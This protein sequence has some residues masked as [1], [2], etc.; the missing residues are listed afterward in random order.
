M[1]K[2]RSS[3][4]ALLRSCPVASFLA[5]GSVSLPAQS[6][7]CIAS[8][9]I[10]TVRSVPCLISSVVAGVVSG[11]IHLRI[12][13]ERRWSLGILGGMLCESLTML[14]VVVWA[15][16]TPLGLDIVAKIALPM[17]LGAVSI[18]LI[19]LLVQGVENEKE[20]IAARQAKLALALDIANKT[21]PYFR[22]INSES[23][24]TV[25]DIIRTDIKADA[26]AITNQHHI[27]AYVGVGAERYNIGHEIISAMTRE[28]IAS[29][30]ITIKKNDEA[31]RTPQI[32]SLII[33]PLW[34]KSVVTGSLKIYYCHA[35]QIT[36]SLKVMA[37]RLS[38]IISTQIEVSRIEQLREMAD[39][40]ELRTLQSKINP[41]FRQRH[42]RVGD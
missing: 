42:Q 36:N 33:I 37:V 18:G 28:T 8:S 27:L 7:V 4:S 40:A 16:P 39:R 13:K 26:V 30:K 29:G 19:V 31:D 10:S 23:L 17:I 11:Y 32:H 12:K 9:S 41:H 1:W 22:H 3:T 24:T 5:P 38:Q 35:H 2:D 25:C 6:P 21:L 20:V 34:E 15:K 14:I